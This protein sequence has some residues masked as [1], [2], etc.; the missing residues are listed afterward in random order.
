[1][2]RNECAPR[3]SVAASKGVQ[4]RL[5]PLSVGLR[6]QLKC[7]AVAVL[8][9]S[10][11]GHAVEDS[12]LPDEEVPGRKIPVIASTKIVHDFIRGSPQRCRPEECSNETRD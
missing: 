2:S 5:L 10:A 12:S 6:N 4:D 11:A 1:M 8:V 7:N 9:R 3:V